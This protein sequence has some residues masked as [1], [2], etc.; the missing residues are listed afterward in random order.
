MV[1]CQKSLCRS[2]RLWG[3]VSFTFHFSDRDRTMTEPR[4]NS[5]LLSNLPDN[6]MK[7][8]RQVTVTSA[9]TGAE[10]YAR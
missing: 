2:Q 3:F 10:N 6:L 9:S 4:A 5:V 7:E 8:Q 1:C